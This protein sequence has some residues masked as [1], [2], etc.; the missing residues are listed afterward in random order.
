MSR[1]NLLLLMV[2][3]LAAAWLPSYGHPVVQAPNLAALG[4]EGVVFE[5]QL[6]P[7]PPVGDLPIG[8]ILQAIRRDKKVVHGT[9]HFV[10]AIE[11]GATMT[12][13]DVTEAEL[14]AA[15]TRLGLQGA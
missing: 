6:G 7:L 1:P 13:D 10:I 9:L 11:I 5:K 3:Q 14:I 2:D 8:D 12:V 4:R 15:L